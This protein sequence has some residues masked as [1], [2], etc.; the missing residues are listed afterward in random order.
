MQHGCA[1]KKDKSEASSERSKKK[2]GAAEDEIMPPT[3]NE[4]AK[5]LDK[6]LSTGNEQS[7][8]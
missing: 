3:E 5:A 7:T 8:T 2:E 4:Q 6:M 1:E